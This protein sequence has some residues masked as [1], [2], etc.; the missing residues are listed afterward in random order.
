[1]KRLNSLAIQ[2]AADAADATVI[3]VTRNGITYA[4]TAH[5]RADAEEAV[6]AHLAAEQPEQAAE[7]E[8][9]Q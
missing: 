8:L 3:H 4:V 5:C 2:C 7:P 6:T 9:F 1:M